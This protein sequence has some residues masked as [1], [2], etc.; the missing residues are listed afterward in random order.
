MKILF[1]IHY[2]LIQR[3]KKKIKKNFLA[4]KLQYNQCKKR[5][6]KRE[7]RIIARGEEKINIIIRRIFTGVC[8]FIY[9]HMRVFF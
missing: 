1:K 7:D 9:V 3:D 8:I 2:F 4:K 6:E 5:E